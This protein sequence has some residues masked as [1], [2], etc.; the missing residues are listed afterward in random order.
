MRILIVEDDTVLGELLQ[1]CM[2]RLEHERVLVC[3]TGQEALSAIEEESF[4]C[5]FVDLR[6]PDTDGLEL[7]AAIKERER[8]LP[9]VMMSGYPTMEYTI[10]AMRQGASDFLTKPFTLQDVALTLLRVTKERQLLLK[11][12]SLQFETQARKQLEEVNR[13]LESKVNEQTRLF[14]ISREIDEI[15]SSEDLYPRIVQLASLLESVEKVSFFLVP[16]DGGSLI[17]M[18][19]CGWLP[20]DS[21][22]QRIVIT[23]DRKREL[24]GNGATHS[25]IGP[26]EI[27]YC[28]ENVPPQIDRTLSCWPMRI[29]GEPFGLLMAVHKQ[30]SNMLPSEESRLFD[31][32]ITKASSAVE[33]MALYESLTSNFYGILKSLVNALEAKDLYTGK[34]SERV[35]RYATETAGIL[36]CSAAQIESMRT[37]GYLHDIGKIGVRDSI[38]HKNGPL[39][40]EEYELVKKHPA[41]GDSIVSELGLIPE[42]RSIIR[43]HHERWDGKGYPDGLA[44]EQIPMLARIVSVVDAF[45]AMTSKRAYRDAMSRE[46][47]IAE[48]RRNSGKQFDPRALDAFLKVVEK[49][50]DRSD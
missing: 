21:W 39:T 18:A 28:F 25:I 27:Q 24:L 37:V 8:G 6:L 10:R 2:M 13:K 7:L 1:E 44:G 16:R 14:H 20:D 4:D 47:A 36:G 29:R 11:E 17:G 32:L 34:H 19:G 23:E 22:P 30:G 35:T 38:L 46:E 40:T 31:F 5:A 41:I 42:E 45:D 3:L 49:I 12:L 43:H 26:D 33:N 48:L 50:G 9:V 15:R